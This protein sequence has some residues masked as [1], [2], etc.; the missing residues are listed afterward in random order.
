VVAKLAG[1]IAF[2]LF[3]HLWWRAGG[4]AAGPVWVHLD[5]APAMAWDVGLLGFFFAAHSGFASESFKRR[6]ALPRE[7]MRRW[8]L[9]LT[10]PVMLLVWGLFVPIG[11]PVIWDARGWLGWPFLAL[12]LVALAGLVWTVRSFSLADFFGDPRA[13]A[14][15]GGAARLSV[16]GAFRLCRHPL[17]FFMSLLA[18]A[19][20]FMPLG[21]ALMAGALVVYVAIGSRLEEAKLERD[22]GPD[23]A[24][25]RAGTP[26]LFPTPAS[27]GR[28]VRGR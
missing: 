27:I 12:R 20:T 15:A 16:A 23:Y 25:Y 6:V 22:F 24:H 3:V 13:G 26:W 1:G 28:A 9:L 18:A 10:L 7:A 19:E 21:R 2:A 14:P 4:V 17:Y 8:Y 5:G 11:Q